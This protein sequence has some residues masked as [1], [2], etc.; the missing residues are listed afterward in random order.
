MERMR[1]VEGVDEDDEEEEE[2]L[3]FL[4]KDWRDSCLDMASITVAGTFTGDKKKENPS[5][6]L[7]PLCG[8]VA[9]SGRKQ[10]Q[11]YSPL[12]TKNSS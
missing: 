7:K 10:T 11:N 3:P 8:A 1:V 2:G 9:A 6:D 12:E 5:V 4:L